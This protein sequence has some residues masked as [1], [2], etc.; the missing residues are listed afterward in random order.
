MWYGGV[1]ADVS[2]MRGDVFERF[3][4]TGSL[5][6]LTLSSVRSSASPSFGGLTLVDSTCIWRRGVRYGVRHCAEHTPAF[7]TGTTFVSLSGQLRIYHVRGRWF[8]H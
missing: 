2:H 7:H 5:L 1:G 4:R 6:R 3:F 8:R